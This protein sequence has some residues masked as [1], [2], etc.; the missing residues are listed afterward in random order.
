MPSKFIHEE[1]FDEKS[2]ICCT[3]GT[4]IV[5]RDVSGSIDSASEGISIMKFAAK[6]SGQA[7]LDE[8]YWK[9]V[10]IPF[11]EVKLRRNARVE[12]LLVVE[13]CE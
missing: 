4:P 9:P 6:S 10:A 3:L 7:L 13:A 2:A 11:E 8:A 5:S 1:V 12:V